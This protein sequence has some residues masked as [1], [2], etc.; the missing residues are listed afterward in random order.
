MIHTTSRDQHMRSLI[1]RLNLL[2]HVPAAAAAPEGGAATD[3]HPG[4]KLPKGGG[5]SGADW[6]R[7]YCEAADGEK[8]IAQAER[9]L[10]DSVR[11]PVERPAGETPEQEIARKTQRVL[12]LHDDGAWT[13]VD[14]AS[15]TGLTIGQ[16][17]KIIMGAAIAVRLSAS[18]R[19]DEAEVVRLWR[20]DQGRT[21]RYL[22]AATGVPKS[23]VQDILRRAA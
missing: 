1:V 11:G 6:W 3:E 12:H 17:S 5:M 13:R 23:T 14:I 15:D 19:K 9:E 10:E 8:I 2:T 18:E 21:V 22:A 20:E 4:G 7:L 16:V